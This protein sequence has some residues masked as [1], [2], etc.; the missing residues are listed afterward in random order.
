MNARE[1]S[2]YIDHTLL[3][4]TATREQLEQVVSE[5]IEYQFRTVC[6]ESKWLSVAAPRLAKSSV[7]PITVISFPGGE[8]SSAEKVREAT[9]AVKLGAREVDM[10]LNR[11]LLAAARYKETLDDIRGVVDAARVPVKVILETSELTDE[12]KAIACALAKAA[13]AA[14]VKT[15]TGFS[16]GG[17]T[18]E[19][20]RLMRRVVGP[21]LGVKASGGIRTLKDAL[22]MI[23]AGA[24]RLGC[25]AS[26]SIVNELSG[27][28][29]VDGGNY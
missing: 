3:L 28:R 7:L 17:A 16:R 15:S 23:E 14:F 21:E 24:T 5:A 4:P 13:G 9:E 25:S 26:V 20:I 18:A 10:V 1:L 11:S 22:M 12:Q 8:R 27:S 29:P 6:I 19:D 2:R